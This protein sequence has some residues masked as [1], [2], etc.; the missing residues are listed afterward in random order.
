MKLLVTMVN[1][2]S[3]AS[4]FEFAAFRRRGELPDLD[5]NSRL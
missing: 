4:I 5:V 2:S 1:H 3:R